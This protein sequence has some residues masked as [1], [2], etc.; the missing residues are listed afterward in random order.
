M[1]LLTVKVDIP[2]GANVIIGQ[3]H[4]IKSVE[5]LYEAMMNTAPGIRFGIAFN[6]SSG[7]CLIRKDGND[8]QL[9]QKAVET[10][11]NI[12]A[13]HIFVI[14]MK[15]GFPIQ[16]LPSIKETREVCRIFCATA[17][18]LEVV[19]CQT[20]QGRGVLGIVDGFSPKGVES[21]ADVKKRI[22]L[23]QKFGYKR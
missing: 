16:V 10:A 9:I 17:N 4:F 1:E 7:P 5:D 22:E 14:F 8:E 21:D 2:E 12:G 11:Q 3:T 19:V 6:E 23:L 20:E 13:G 18:P 15:E